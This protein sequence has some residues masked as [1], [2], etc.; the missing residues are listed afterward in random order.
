MR[1]M[2]CEVP[3]D[4]AMH[5]HLSLR[6]HLRVVLGLVGTFGLQM[7]F[8]RDLGAL[9]TI[10]V[11]H[12]AERASAPA[13]QVLREEEL[14]LPT[15]VHVFVGAEVE[16]EPEVAAGSEEEVERSCVDVPRGSA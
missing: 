8:D 14:D 16:M 4:L 6:L 5:V 12:A 3:Q 15:T 2:R 11:A 1:A 13:F 9:H 10:L 7:G